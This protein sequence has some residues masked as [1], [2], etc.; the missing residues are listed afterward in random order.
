MLS[1]ALLIKIIIIAAVVIT[2]AAV[3]VVA[4]RFVKRAAS[5][6]EAQVVKELVNI[7]SENGMDFISE[8]EHPKLVSNMNRI[9]LP[10]IEK[11]FPDFNWDEIR[12]MIE[13]EIT[14]KFSE[15]QN[16]EIDETAVS[17]YEK[18]GQNRKITCETAA[19]YDDGEMKKY[20]CIQTLLSYINSKSLDG[21]QAGPQA[22][23][24]PSCGAPLTRFDNGDVRCEF[25]S[26]VVVGEK[27]WQITEIKEK[28]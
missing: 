12:R 7:V 13:K 3:V 10:K 5:S 26:T 28:P 16:F 27:I 25:C 1:T 14:D 6:A 24:C 2:A 9:Y 22:L 8:P 23:I 11:D 19:S 21:E 17:R 4:V 20:T 15:K 18:S